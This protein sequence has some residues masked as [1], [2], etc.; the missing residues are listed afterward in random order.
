VFDVRAVVQRPH[1]EVTIHDLP[2]IVR[3]TR[4]RYAL[5]DHEKVFAPDARDDIFDRR[6]IDRAAGAV[7][8]VR[9]DQHVAHVLP[10]DAYDELAAFFDA[11]MT[12]A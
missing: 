3:P 4:G 7:V 1:H 11:F 8:V 9:P 12:R 2:P 6:G 10:L 5:V